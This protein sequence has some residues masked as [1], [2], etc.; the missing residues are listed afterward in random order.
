MKRIYYILTLIIFIFGFHQAQAQT[1]KLDNSNDGNTI[2]TC[3]GTFTD[4][5]GTTGNYG[6]SQHR[7][8]TFKSNSPNSKIS[9][10][11]IEFSLYCSWFYGCDYMKIYQGPNTSSPV[12]YLPGIAQSDSTYT[13]QALQGK[14]ITPD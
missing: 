5:G 4:D 13:Y 9:I 12:L 7:I 14:T 2:Q 10:N 3:S 8:I 1:Y 6:K 11:F